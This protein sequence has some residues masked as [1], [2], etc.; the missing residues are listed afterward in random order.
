FDDELFPAAEAVAAVAEIGGDTTDQKIG[1]A[2]RGLE[3]PCEHGG[4]GGLAMRAG[5][6]NRS[7]ARDEIFLEQLGHGAIR[8][9][10]GEDSLDFGIASRDGVADDGEIGGGL[11]IFLAIAFKPRDA[12]RTE[13]SGCGWIDV[14]VRTGDV[15]SALF[16]HAGDG[17]HGCSGDAEQVD[18]A[19]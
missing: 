2:A 11:E 9:G 5:N 3:D 13:K 12:E 18:V 4:G 17:G 16:E 8:D 15:E 7:V 6:D 10:V 1:A 14:D 19:R